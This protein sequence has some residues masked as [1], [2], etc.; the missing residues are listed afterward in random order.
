M[1]R[2]VFLIKG[3]AKNDTE[4]A[5]LVE[6][7]SKYKE[8]FKD[9]SGGAYR[10]EEILTFDQPD[11]KELQEK[12][13]AEKLD[14]M[15]AVFLGH[16]ADQEATQL[17]QLN[18]SEIILAGQVEFSAS[19]QL[20]LMESCRG[21]LIGIPVVKQAN[22]VAK[23]KK[24]GV[25]ERPLTITEIRT[26]Y[27]EHIKRC[28]EGLVIGYACSLDEKA[29]GF[30]YSQTIL[31]LAHEAH[32]DRRNKKTVIGI[33]SFFPHVSSNVKDI[34]S[35]YSKSQTPVLRGNADYPIIVSKF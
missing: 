26:L 12:I 10:E 17:F 18:G 23:F 28:D 3:F 34:A 14:Y 4:T 5:K 33:Q 29:S 24:G 25:L 7:L 30:F 31:T 19:K 27:D 16:G 20:V 32:N 11:L 35:Q 13:I 2:K 22:K 8:F 1:T 15:I 6:Y 9:N 21:L